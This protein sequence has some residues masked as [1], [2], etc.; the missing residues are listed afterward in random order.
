MSEEHYEE[1]EE[2]LEEEEL[3][4]DS[5][6]VAILEEYR[7]RKFREM[8]VGPILSLVFHVFAISVMMI[9]IKGENS[10]E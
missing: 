6:I 5:E 9:F 1:G 7:R 2:V 4:E 8:L 3:L 10:T